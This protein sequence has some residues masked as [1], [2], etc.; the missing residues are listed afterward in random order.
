VAELLK[1]YL[2]DSATHRDPRANP[3]LA[4]AALFPP[5][6]MAAAEVDT[7]RDSSVR[8]AAKLAAAG[9]THEL[10][11]YPGMTHLFF[12]YSRMVTTARGCIADMAAF[13]RKHLPPDATLMP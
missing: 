11:I 9:V 8:M 13:L 6:F 1:N 5:L 12:G 4:D 10:K 7:L 2:P 3:I